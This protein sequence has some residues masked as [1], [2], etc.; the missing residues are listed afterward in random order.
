MRTYDCLNCKKETQA[1]NQKANKYCCIPCQKEYEYKKNIE[2]WLAGN[3][4]GGN[5][6][7]TKVWIKRYVVEDQQYKC[8]D[9]GITEH[10]GKPIVLELDH[11]DGD[12][13]N[14]SRD[15]LRA[16]C[17]NCHSQSSTYKNRNRGNGKRKRIQ[18]YM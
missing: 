7:G 1:T 13:Y 16:I 6:Y 17:P 9:C 8:N 2:S 12:A 14:N 4:T 15:N 10:M 18:V 3:S 5:K 11:I